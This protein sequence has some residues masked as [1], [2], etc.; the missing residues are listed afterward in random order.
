MLISKN[1][2]CL[3]IDGNLD[4]LDLMLMLM[5]MLK[6]K[7]YKAVINQYQKILIDYTNISG[8]TPTSEDTF[9]ISMLGKMNLED[10]GKITTVIAVNENKHAVIEKIT[11]GI[12]FDSQSII[13]MSDSTSDALKLLGSIWLDKTPYFEYGCDDYFEL[14]QYKVLY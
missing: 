1:I 11:K 7:N 2:A 9:A 14:N 12:F 5:F 6:D 13:L 10:L 8:V 4:A 3:T